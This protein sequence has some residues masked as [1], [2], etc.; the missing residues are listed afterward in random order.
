MRIPHSRL[1]RR[2]YLAFAL[3]N[4]GV[5]IMRI[6]VSHQRLH[7]LRHVPRKGIAHLNDGRQIG[8]T[9]FLHLGQ[10][11]ASVLTTSEIQRNPELL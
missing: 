9:Q 1:G 2:A 10:I 4:S 11:F 6:T 5:Q 8:R 3:D 7:Q